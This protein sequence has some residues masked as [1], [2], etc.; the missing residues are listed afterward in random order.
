MTPVVATISIVATKNHRKI[1]GRVSNHLS[2][3]ALIKI[4][5]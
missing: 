2:S 4:L 3:D 5:F 1:V